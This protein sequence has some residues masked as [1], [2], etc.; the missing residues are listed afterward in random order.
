MYLQSGQILNGTEVANGTTFE[1]HCVKP[2]ARTD[3]VRILTCLNGKLDG[4]FPTCESKE[5]FK[6][7]FNQFLKSRPKFN[8]S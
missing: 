5:L 2:W 3:G 7:I 6:N 8:A 1:V 4:E